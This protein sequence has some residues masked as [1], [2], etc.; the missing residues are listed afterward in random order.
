MN[1][2]KKVREVKYISQI[3]EISFGFRHA[4]QKHLTFRAGESEK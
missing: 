3:S 2:E 4:L 1:K